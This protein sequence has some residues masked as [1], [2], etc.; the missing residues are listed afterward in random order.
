MTINNELK[1]TWR[2]QLE[3]SQ[4]ELGELKSS[5]PELHLLFNLFTVK[6][7]CGDSVEWRLELARQGFLQTQ[8]AVIIAKAKTWSKTFSERFVQEKGE[9]EQ[10][11]C[12]YYSQAYEKLSQ[13]ASTFASDHADTLESLRKRAVEFE[14]IK[15]TSNHEIETTL[16]KYRL[17]YG[18]AIKQGNDALAGQ[19]ARY[20]AVLQEMLTKADQD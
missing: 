19:F 17:R 11:L 18:M 2:R 8:L 16:N 9:D 14:L 12:H 4:T 6:L 10:C 5:T 7:E 3:K 15:L 13:E 20:I 1:E